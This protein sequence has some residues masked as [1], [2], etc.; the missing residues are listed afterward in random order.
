MKIGK[1][2]IGDNH[3]CFVVAEIS[4]N[5]NGSIELAEKTI[6]EAKKAGAN[7]VKLQTYTPDTITLDC[8]KEDF[9]ISGG[10]LWDGKTLYELY[11]EA[12]TPWEWHKH[13]FSV[14][15]EIGITIFSSPFDKT[16]VDFLEELNTPAYKI[17]SFEIKDIPLIEYA[18]SKKKPIILSSG[19][20][21]LEDIE[22]AIK[23]CKEAGNDQIILLKCT[24]SYPTPLE[25]AN[26]NTIKDMKERFG[27]NIGFSDHTEGS[28]APVI[29][30]S[31]GACL[32]EKHVILDKSVGGPDADFSLT[33]NDFEEMVNQ[34]RDTEKILGNIS[35][36]LDK[37]IKANLRFSRS[38]Y[39]ACDIA[40]GE[41]ITELN[42]RSV[43]PGYGMHPKHLKDIIGK[44]ANTDITF[45]SRI[46][47]GNI[48]Q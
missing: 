43:R 5:H 19:I 25:L 2:S 29:A 18:A 41:K 22:L 4:A 15:N 13:L 14:A 16:S 33:M 7:A 17:A 28:L 37:K 46:L 21:S 24:S 35:Y 9:L 8:N 31:L 3:P 27:I 44:K 11:E 34:V 38:L 39:A 10:T 20:A 32:I 45:G 48:K 30:R 12:Y 47:K 1:N 23:T 6:R 26:L 42:V 40:K 36:D